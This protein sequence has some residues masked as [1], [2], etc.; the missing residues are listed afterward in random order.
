[1]DQQI[2]AV[3]INRKDNKLKKGCG[4]HLDLFVLAFLIVILSLFGLPWFV[5]ATVESRNHLM[6]LSKESKESAPG[7]KTNI[8]RYKG[9]KS[10]NHNDRNPH[11][12]IHIHYSCACPY[13]NADII[14]DFLIY[15]CKIPKRSSILRSTHF[16]LYANKYQPDYVFLKICSFETSS[17]FYYYTTGIP[18]LSMVDQVLSNN[19]HRLP[20]HARHHLGDDPDKINELALED[21][22]QLLLTSLPNTRTR[23]MT[24]NE[25]LDN[26]NSS[27]LDNNKKSNLKKLNKIESKLSRICFGRIDVNEPFVALNTK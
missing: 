23:K 20:S 25:E 26:V 7:E 19:L 13:T 6:A 17:F 9:T 10:Y 3:I 1:M 2:T 12:P 18:Y 16:I 21:R 14:R 11:W 8:S 24:L 22:D 27:I 4:Y 15:G 5:A